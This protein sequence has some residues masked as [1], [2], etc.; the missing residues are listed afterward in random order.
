M[1]IALFLGLIILS[2]TY[3][4]CPVQNSGAGFVFV[5]Y[6]KLFVLGFLKSKNNLV[7][8]LV[9]YLF[10]C[11]WVYTSIGVSLF[12]EKDFFSSAECG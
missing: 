5:R 4:V 1:N 10:K 11:V 3:T 2:L 8:C 6:F 9:T 7:I 12:F